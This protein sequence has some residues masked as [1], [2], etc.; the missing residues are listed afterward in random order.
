M[1]YPAAIRLAAI[2][3]YVK[4]DA[5]AAA[6]ARE[7]GVDSGTL[8]AWLRAAGVPVRSLAGKIDPRVAAA[9]PK[10]ATLFAAGWCISC[11]AKEVG[12]HRQTV[13]AA[14]RAHGIATPLS[15]PGQRRNPPPPCEVANQQRRTA[16]R[17]TGYGG[18]RT[19][20]NPKRTTARPVVG[21]E[22]ARNW[23]AERDA[24]IATGLPQRVAEERATARMA[25]GV[26]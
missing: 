20:T 13:T 6:V 14:A 16:R 2:D 7:F 5:T 19:A 21:D 12:L 11:V 18:R 4:S 15:G 22:W 8:R 3:A 24:L 9:L 23:T 17:S 1:T 26:A 25:K 10:I